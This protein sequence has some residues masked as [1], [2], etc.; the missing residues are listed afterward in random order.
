MMILIHDVSSRISNLFSNRSRSISS[1]L[2]GWVGSYVR[3]S[4]RRTNGRLA[5]CLAGSENDGSALVSVSHSIEENLSRCAWARS[6]CRDGDS[7]TPDSEFRGR[8]SSRH[9]VRVFVVSTTISLIRDAA[10]M[11]TP[12]AA[13]SVSFRSWR[14]SSGTIARAATRSPSRPSP[15]PTAP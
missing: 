2:D 1:V 9:Q 6:S 14:L 10:P 11:I 4:A 15:S 13:C 3:Q 7:C 12:L 5:N 8:C